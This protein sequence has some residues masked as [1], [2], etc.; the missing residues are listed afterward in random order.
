[1]YTT[2]KIRSLISLFTEPILN[3]VHAF[4]INHFMTSRVSL[5]AHI[6]PFYFIFLS[7]LKI[8]TQ[9]QSENSSKN[10]SINTAKIIWLKI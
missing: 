1:M 5:Q 2:L 8:Y 6:V 4:D 7:W 10:S 3:Q 9:N